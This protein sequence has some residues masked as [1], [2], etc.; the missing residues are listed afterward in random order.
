MAFAGP[1]SATHSHAML[2][3]NGKCVIIAEDAGEEN[4]ALPAGVF[5]NNPNVDV[6]MVADRMHPLH[7]LVHQ[8]VAGEGGKIQVY[9]SAAGNAM[10]SAG[11]INR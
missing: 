9:G 2:L 3:G 1:A 7:V 5:E 4:V 10:C 11:Y 8:G 6:G